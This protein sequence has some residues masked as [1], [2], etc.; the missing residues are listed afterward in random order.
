[1]NDLR[2]SSVA[3]ALLAALA[4]AAAAC[5]GSAS[6]EPGGGGGASAEPAPASVDAGGGS[7]GGVALPGDFEN[8]L[9]PP[10]SSVTFTQQAGNAKS[11]IFHSDASFDELKSFYESAVAALGG[12]KFT[13][14]A[15]GSLTIGFGDEGSGTGGLVV[16]V[17][18]SD[19]GGGYDVSV[20]TSIGG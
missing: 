12:S 15:E 2:R 13:Q 4:L 18:S 1:M 17:P 9:V 16:V 19:G 8:K 3:I 5:G 11:V 14:E 20:T 7:G 6:Q 10:K